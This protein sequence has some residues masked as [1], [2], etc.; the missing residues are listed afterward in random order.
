[1]WM[2]TAKQATTIPNQATLAARDFAVDMCARPWIVELS[3]NWRRVAGAII[4]FFTSYQLPSN[5][6]PTSESF[7]KLCPFSNLCLSAQTG[8]VALLKQVE[9]DRKS[10]NSLS[11]PSHGKFSWTQVHFGTDMIFLV[12]LGI[13]PAWTLGLFIMKILPDKNLWL[14]WL[15]INDIMISKRCPTTS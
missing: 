2:A 8:W 3:R 9:I 11:P 6:D 15:L 1:M 7:S 10:A 4:T 12:L 5:S 13:L 14:L